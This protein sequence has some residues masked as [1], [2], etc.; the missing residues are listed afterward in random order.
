MISKNKEQLLKENKKL[1]EDI[2]QLKKLVAELQNKK[3]KTYNNVKESY[4]FYHTLFQFSPSGIII[5][6]KNG[7]I[8]DVNPAWCKLLGYKR[9]EIIG[10]KVH[11]LAHPENR[12]KVDKNIKNILADKISKH[13]VKSIKKDG[14]ECYIQLN[15]REIKLPNGEQ[16]IISISQDMTKEAQA[17]EALEESEKSYRGLFNNATDAIYIQDKKGRFVDVNQAVVKMYGYP[18]EYFIG[19][20][21]KPLSAPGRNDLN[22]IALQIEKAFKDKPQQFEFYGKR[23]NGEVFPKMVRLHKGIYF[24]QEVIFAFAIDITE[25]KRA[26]QKLLESKEKFRSMVEHSHACVM[27]IDD[28]Y[29]IKYVNDKIKEITGYDASELIGKDFR[30]IISG[31]SKNEIIQ[32]YQIREKSKNKYAIYEYK[33]KCKEGNIKWIESRASVY[34]DAEGKLITIAQILDITERKKSEKALKES[35][36][37]LALLNAI[38]WV[39]TMSR[40]PEEMSKKLANEICKVFPVDAF[41]V[42]GFHI[43][44]TIS[45]DF[46]FYDTINGKFQPVENPAKRFDWMSTERGKKL[47]KGK[48]PICVFRTLEEINQIKKIRKRA[49]NNIPPSASFIHVPLVLGKKITGVISVQSYSMNI[50]SKKDI[51]LLEAVGRQIAPVVEGLMLD[52]ELLEQTQKLKESEEKFRVLAEKSPNMI[53]INVKGK[54]VYANK[55]CEEIIGY[56]RDEFYNPNFDF[57][58]LIAKDS[59]AAIMKNFQKH[60]KGIDI[61]PYEYSLIT[62]SGDTINS[63]IATKLINYEDQ[64]AIL[65]IVTD[66]TER[67]KSEDALQE[68][69]ERFRTMFS[70]NSAVMLLVDPSEN[71]NILDANKAAEKFYGYNRSQLLQMH[72][73]HINVLENESRKELMDQALIRQQNYF[74]FKH[75]LASG[76]IKDVE[77][78]ASPIMQQEKKCMFVIVHDITERK[79]AEQQINRLATVVEQAVESIIITEVDGTI[80]YVNTAFEKITGYKKSE[81]LGQNPRMLKSG[82]H[83]KEFYKDLWNT[84][85]SGNKWQGVIINKRKNG[86]YYYEKAVIFPIK[87]EHDEVINFTAIMRDI[88]LERKLEQQLQQVQK[89]EAIGTLSGGIAHDFNNILTVINGHAEI[90]LM[91]TDQSNVLHDDLISILNAGKRA[92]K[93]T[94]QLLAFSRKQIHE[95]KVIDINQTIKDLDKMIIRLI[96]EDIKI[97]SEFPEDLPFIKADPGQIEQILINLIINARDA[98]N[99]KQ[100]KRIQ[101]KIIIKTKLV[102][103]DHIFVDTHPGS[104]TGPHILLSV[105]DNGAGMNIDVQDRIFEPFFTT[106]D[107]DKGTG[108]G[109][110]TVYGIVKQNEGSIYVKTELGIG[111]TFEIYWPITTESPDKDYIETINQNAFAGKET[112]LFV[113][114]DEDVRKFACVALRSFGYNVIEAINGKNALQLIEKENT[115][116][117]VIITDLI[118]PEM[119]GQ[120][121]ASQVHKLIPDLEVL[122]VSGYTFEHL[123]KD[124]EIDD[125]INF[126]QK[127]YTIQTILKS[128]REILDKK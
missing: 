37:N 54:I 108:L 121:L 117:D 40:T 13:I 28:K 32:R 72:M 58:S 64:K 90:G 41:I 47:L 116:I 38:A 122:F 39:T 103:L 97:I 29:R 30:Q 68:S 81:A 93:L 100:D 27:L 14:T 95:L 126:L 60:S 77:V 82:R 62:K 85:L 80:R 45:Y 110:A 76:E 118:M 101:K 73:E 127:P 98:I 99:E 3:T 91:N 44:T 70:Q 89:M 83:A 88:T 51:E 50:Y 17:K 34:K 59:I 109:L 114:D 25:Q 2:Q 23:S 79:I 8:L 87:N 26:E 19:K 120:E 21:P 55:K 119:N 20:T 123:L 86:S 66:I 12:D 5:E 9:Q 49:G 113:E 105:K 33:F 18:K 57:L 10:K 63:I 125:S 16:G 107:V 78:Y 43:G 22:K 61:N 102:D 1:L 124:G 128:L 4:D 53:F 84:I 67:K 75:R 104:Q 7:T 111:T 92:E 115:S 65:G 24:G 112:I 52:K 6:D 35:N 69:E 36:Q 96:P 15:E 94:N 31:D 106:K 71:Q 11:T 74:Q 48:K 42:C 56:T 46:G